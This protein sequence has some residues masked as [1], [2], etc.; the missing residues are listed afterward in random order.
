MLPALEPNTRLSELRHTHGISINEL[1]VRARC[2]SATIEA[3]EK[4]G[5]VPRAETRERF[6]AALGVKPEELW[7]DT[8]GD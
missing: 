4:Y 7:P 6:A 5:R 3:V 8:S 2:S 1:S